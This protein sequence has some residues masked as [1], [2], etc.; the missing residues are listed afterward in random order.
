[1]FV[2]RIFC[3]Y[4]SVLICLCYLLQIPDFVIIS[5][6]TSKVK[7]KSPN[8]AIVFRIHSRIMLDDHFYFL[9]GIEAYNY[10]N[11]RHVLTH[12]PPLFER[13]PNWDV[14]HQLLSIILKLRILVLFPVSTVPYVVKVKNYS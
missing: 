13:M 8:S 7:V 12:Y 1:M 3:V 2:L 10:E 9:L 4:F 6:L 14:F 5:R 11:G